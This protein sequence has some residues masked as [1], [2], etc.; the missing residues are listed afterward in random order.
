MNQTVDDLLAVIKQKS[1]VQDYN[2]TDEEAMGILLAKF[3]DYDGVAILE[4]AVHAL[5]EANFTT[6]SE[7]LREMIHNQLY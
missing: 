5:E 2:A 6:E 7:Q 1:F 3:F 4:V